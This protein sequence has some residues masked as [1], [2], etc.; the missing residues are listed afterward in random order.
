MRDGHDALIVTTGVGLQVCLAA[1]D[2]LSRGDRRDGAAHADGE[3][4]RHGI[5]R[6]GGRTRAACRDGRGAQRRRRPG[7]AVA[8]F[9][10]ENDLPRQPQV[11]PCGFPDVFPAGYGDQ[12]GMMRRYGITAEAVAG[13]VTKLLAGR[14]RRILTGLSRSGHWPAF[15]KTKPH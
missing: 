6:D 9:L 3:A 1:A 10:A 12:A 2:I 13:C 15:E 7:S 8:E 14:T 5:A 11:P 4:A